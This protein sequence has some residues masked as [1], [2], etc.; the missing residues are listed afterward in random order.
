MELAIPRILAVIGLGM[1]LACCAAAGGG[2][3]SYGYGPGGSNFGSY[4]GP[5]GGHGGVFAGGA[6]R[7]REKKEFA[8]KPILA[9]AGLGL[10]LAGCAYGPAP[11][12]YGYAPSGYGYGGYYGYAPAYSY[13]AYGY[14]Y[15][16]GWGGYPGANSRERVASPGVGSPG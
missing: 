11:G 12:E 4:D 13:G 9:V 5:K 14:G 1:M 8:M 7:N 10:L 15:A 6:L 2:G 16:S 3:Y